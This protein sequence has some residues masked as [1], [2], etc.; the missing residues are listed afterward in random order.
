MRQ[1]KVKKAK[2][3]ELNENLHRDSASSMDNVDGN[4][5][6]NVDIVRMS[7][8]KEY[9]GMAPKPKNSLA[10]RII[11]PK[12]K[13]LGEREVQESSFITRSRCED[14]DRALNQVFSIRP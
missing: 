10:R 2:F 4:V 9:M 8:G 6:P 5:D 7:A 1:E 13:D 12:E 3:A 11:T 14:L